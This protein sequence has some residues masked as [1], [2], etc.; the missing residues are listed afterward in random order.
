MIFTQRFCYKTEQL[1][2]LSEGQQA[3]GGSGG[4][5]TAEAA[6]VPSRPGPWTCPG[7]DRDLS[8]LKRTE[9]KMSA[10]LCR[11]WVVIALI[12]AF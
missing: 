1:A 9:R 10:L 4:A 8:G 2:F 7:E 5:E 6:P 12:R 3:F 11:P